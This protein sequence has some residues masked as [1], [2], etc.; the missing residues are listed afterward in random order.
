[1]RARLSLIGSFSISH[2]L[3]ALTFGPMR[4]TPIGLGVWDPS[5]SSNSRSSFSLGGDPLREKVI[6]AGTP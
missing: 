1:M 4:I 2:A 6:V 3:Y 5:S